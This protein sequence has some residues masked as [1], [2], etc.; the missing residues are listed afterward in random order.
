MKKILCFL[1]IL[2]CF[3]LTGCK[4][5]E[6]A[7]YEGIYQ[8][9]LTE[10]DTLVSGA[11]NNYI[12]FCDGIM[13]S[14]KTEL[15]PTLFSECIIYQREYKDL[16]FKDL[17]AY[18][19]YG[20]FEA[21]LLAN[22]NIDLNKLNEIRKVMKDFDGVTNTKYK[23]IGDGWICIKQDYSTN[24]IWLKYID[25]KLYYIDSKQGYMYLKKI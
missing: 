1:M 7:D 22:A 2:I 8:I 10:D 12:W 6:D 18:S 16:M 20:S 14:Y 21:Y 25:N 15:D 5:N 13:T 9:F 23:Y 4:N 24:T 17:V 3:S 11:Q 19:K